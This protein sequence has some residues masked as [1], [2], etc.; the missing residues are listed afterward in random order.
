MLGF[1][2]EIAYKSRSGVLRLPRRRHK[3]INISDEDVRVVP[4]DVDEQRFAQ[5]LVALEDLVGPLVLVSA[6]ILALDHQAI[7]VPFRVELLLALVLGLFNLAAIREYIEPAIKIIGDVDFRLFLRDGQ[8]LG[9]LEKDLHLLALF[10]AVVP[11]Q[12]PGSREILDAR[13]IR[14]RLSCW[15]GP[16]RILGCRP[17]QRSGRRLRVRVCGKRKSGQRQERGGRELEHSYTSGSHTL[18]PLFG[19]PAAG[20][21]V[22]GLQASK[23]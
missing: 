11:V 12:F 13:S 10:V 2:G 1:R 14:P 6:R 15:R 7:L 19:L 4:S 22:P 20:E 8:L 21:K 5:L 16:G 3:I 18:S 23:A 9:G 17:R